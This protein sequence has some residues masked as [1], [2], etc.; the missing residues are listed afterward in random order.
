[1]IF[2]F[3]GGVVATHAQEKSI[4]IDTKHEIDIR[5]N[6]VNQLMYDYTWLSKHVD[7]NNCNGE[8]IDVFKMKNGDTKFVLLEKGD[9]KIMY[10]VK[11]EQYCANSEELDCIEFYE[12]MPTGDTWKCSTAE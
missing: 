10:D 8:R 4:D 1:M 12:L 2:F 11:G 3:V 6:K 5:D 9:R 7:V